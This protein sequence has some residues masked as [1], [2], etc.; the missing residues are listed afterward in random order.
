MVVKQK[1]KNYFQQKLSDNY[2]RPIFLSSKM[3]KLNNI[4]KLNRF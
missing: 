3:V 2:H 1:V 4:L